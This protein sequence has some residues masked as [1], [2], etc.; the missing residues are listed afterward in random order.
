MKR[1]ALTLWLLALVGCST[2]F[3]ASFN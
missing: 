1:L 3:D 2:D